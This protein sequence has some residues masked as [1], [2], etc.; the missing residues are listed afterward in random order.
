MLDLPEKMYFKIGEVADLVDVKP[1]VLRYWER[2][3]RLF[4]PEKSR[5]N[6]RV[7]R[8]RDVELIAAIKRLLYDEGY[9]IAGARK[10][11]RDELRANA[12]GARPTTR[13]VLSDPAADDD[14]LASADEPRPAGSP[15][16]RG[17]T[18]ASRADGA[19]GGAAA[20]PRQGELWGDAPPVRAALDERTTP[21]PLAESPGGEPPRSHPR[22]GP[23]DS[24]PAHVPGA[25]PIG[26]EAW[27]RQSGA[28]DPAQGAGSA[29]KTAGVLEPPENAP[30]PSDGD[31]SIRVP[32]FGRAAGAA[33]APGSS[34]VEG[35]REAL[36]REAR[37]RE[38][39]ERQVA[40]IRRAAAQIVL[41][42]RKELRDMQT[43]FGVDGSE[44][45]PPGAN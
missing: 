25:K 23:S 5:S 12:T 30:L 33:P 36:A 17:V 20:L 26:G 22:P 31:A 16:S 24:R 14:P 19:S 35:L 39:L 40:R 4:R 32:T 7:Y 28:A 2:E 6:H 18:P 43:I 29:R 41:E 9:T 27:Q 44:K 10:R 8:R 1:H 11:L 13:D 21:P 45:R 15:R 3:F 37:R 38:A 34:E 42:L